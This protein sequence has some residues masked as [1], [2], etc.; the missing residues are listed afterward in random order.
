ML[1][2]VAALLMLPLAGEAEADGPF[3]KAKA[4]GAEHSALGYTVTTVVY[5]PPGAACAPEPVRVKRV[6]KRGCSYG[7]RARNFRRWSVAVSR[8]IDHNPD[9]SMS[10]YGLAARLRLTYRLSAAVE[11]GF[12]KERRHR[13]HDR[14]WGDGES[15]PGWDDNRDPR[16]DEGAP[17]PER[18]TYDGR[19]GVGLIY[20]LAP[21]WRVS[22][23][24]TANGGMLFS[25]LRE[26][27]EPTQ[28]LF[29][30]VGAGLSVRVYR[31]LYLQGEAMIGKRKTRRDDDDAQRRLTVIEPEDHRADRYVRGRI[32]AVWVF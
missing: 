29:G 3:S 28:K 16:L 9:R 30:E 11:L 31:R 8:G 5:C 2:A 7:Y 4:D 20:T 1:L 23:Y 19:V 32:N 24:L 27:S 10:E 18:R 22:P 14:D 6:V 12:S 17:V 13:H 25:D 15:R 26:E 21:T